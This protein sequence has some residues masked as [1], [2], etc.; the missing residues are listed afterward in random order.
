MLGQTVLALLFTE[1]AMM[2]A[3]LAT[4]Y[5]SVIP[6]LLLYFVPPNIKLT[7]LNTLVHFA[8]GNKG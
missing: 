3:L 1:N 8:I 6:N 5:I 4:T 7:T 2:N